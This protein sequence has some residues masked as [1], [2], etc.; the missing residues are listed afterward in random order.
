MSRYKVGDKVTIIEEG[1]TLIGKIATITKVINDYN[2]TFYTIDLDGGFCK[3]FDS[4][5]KKVYAIKRQPLEY[6]IVNIVNDFEEGVEFVSAKG[7]DMRY[8]ILDGNL[9]NY[10]YLNEEW[11]RST[12]AIS[13]ILNMK[14]TKAEDPKLKPMTFEEAVHT[15]KNVK[16]ELLNDKQDKFYPPNETIQSIVE[17]YPVKVTAIILNG[18]WYAEGV[19]E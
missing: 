12:L 5:F 16:Y 15:L 6:T 18:T 10:K 2:F 4:C 3:F 9:F 13:K 1:S 7:I 14:F 8:K 19:Y 11:D 17:L